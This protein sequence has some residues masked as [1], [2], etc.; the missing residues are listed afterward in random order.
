MEIHP[1]IDPYHTGA[2]LSSS[3]TLVIRLTSCRRCLA[4]GDQE[5][6][7]GGERRVADCPRCEGVG[8]CVRVEVTDTNGGS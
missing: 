7:I 1:P 4:T 3:V 8:L 5:R 2:S 6:W